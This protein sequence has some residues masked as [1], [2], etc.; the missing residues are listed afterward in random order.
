MVTVISS[1]IIFILTLFIHILFRRRGG[2][3]DK[4][5]MQIYL[6][7]VY[8]FGLNIVVSYYFYT[9]AEYFG[10]PL[11]FSSLILYIL[12][13]FAYIIFAASPILGEESPS[14]VIILLAKKYQSVDY[15]DIYQELSKQDPIKKRLDDLVIS[16]WIVKK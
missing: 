8:G 6:D 16:K 5:S 13:S 4:L 15:Q 12:I 9:K 14:S 2:L 7:F 1:L 10:E 11:I 3:K